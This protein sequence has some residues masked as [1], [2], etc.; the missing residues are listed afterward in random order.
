MSITTA[1]IVNLT[2]RIKA[3]SET[4]GGFLRRNVLS[5]YALYFANYASSLLTLPYLART[6]RPSAFGLLAASQAYAWCIQMIVEY[7]FNF[8]GTKAAQVRRK[9]KEALGQLIGD[10]H[11]AKVLLFVACCCLTLG[12][13]RFIPAFRTV[14]QLLFFSLL[15]GLAQGFTPVW[16]YQGIDRM[17][18]YTV[19]DSA[20]R[21]GSTLAIF[22]I[23]RSPADTGLA[24]GAQAIGSCVSTV[25]GLVIAWRQIPFR[26]ASLKGIKERLL[27]GSSFFVYRLT[28]NVQMYANPLLLSFFAAPRFV[29]FYS[30]PERLA[31]FFLGTIGP[32]SEGVYPYLSRKFDESHDGGK[33]IAMYSLLVTASVTLCISAGLFITAPWFIPLVLGK[34]FSEAIPVIRV[35]AFLPF[36]AGIVNS[37]GIQWMIPMGL[38]KKYNTITLSSFALHVGLSSVLCSRWQHLGMA[39][40][41]ILSQAISAV[42]MSFLIHRNLACRPAGIGKPVSSL[43][44]AEAEEIASPVS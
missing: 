11:G 28:Y 25:I 8:S 34:N 22:E 26:M 5:L 20:I 27:E 6:L 30:G 38:S 9:D 10:I 36:V 17:K 19:L 12:T 32:F 37:L 42:A 18:L 43:E 16:I 3:L 35:L 2:K 4:E 24:M 7:G 29:A 23:V 21:L 39:S 33:K 40:S 15:F 31:K 41:V 13:A 44:L 1:R 14:P